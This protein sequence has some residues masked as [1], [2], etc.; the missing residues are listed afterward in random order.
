[1]PA[2]SFVDTNIWVYAHL[3]KISDP[4]HP[5][6]LA[7]VKQLKNGFISPQVVAEYYN[8]MLKNGKDDAWIQT[9]LT[10]IMAYTRMQ[11]LDSSLVQRALTIRNRYGF[12][13][14]D[15]QIVAAALEA[16]CAELF[17]EDMQHGQIIHG[18]LR[19]VNPILKSS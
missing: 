4:R 11:P 16:G 12:S 9:N 3:R 5:L 6:A 18:V 19:I 15:C 7:F 10:S 13:Y 2:S 8:V 1:M 17:T 14:W